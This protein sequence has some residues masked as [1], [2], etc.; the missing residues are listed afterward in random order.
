MKLI[1]I[2][3]HFLT[4]E[5]RQA[6]AAIG[7]D[8]VDPSVAFHSGAIEGRLRDLAEGRL[9]LRQGGDADRPDLGFPQG[10]ARG[11][12]EGSEPNPIGEPATSKGRTG[13]SPISR[14]AERRLPSV[15]ETGAIG[16]VEPPSP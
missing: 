8:A 3:E 2:E 15:A 14:R 5:L 12:A 4:V 9:A 10:R 11:L 1:G 16:R 13:W 6:W 7:L